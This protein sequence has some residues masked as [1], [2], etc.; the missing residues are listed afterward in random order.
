MDCSERP[1]HNNS[2]C[3][4]LCFSLLYAL[5]CRTRAYRVSGASW[6][7]QF[8]STL[9][10]C[11]LV[12]INSLSVS[13]LQLAGIIGI[14]PNHECMAMFTLLD[15]SGSPYPILY[16]SP[17]I[18]SIFSRYDFRCFVVFVSPQPGAMFP[19]GFRRFGLHILKWTSIGVRV[20]TLKLGFACM[21]LAS[22]SFPRYS[23]Y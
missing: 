22:G 20:R 6:C 12:L 11:S 3:Y 4:V 10:F 8:T 14:I 23:V 16:F 18:C 21:F 19:L 13:K 2:G 5:V 1:C 15:G 9:L 7:G 17:H